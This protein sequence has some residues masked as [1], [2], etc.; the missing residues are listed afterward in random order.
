MRTAT[1]TVAMWFGIAAGI[2]GL[3]HGYFEILQGNTRPQGLMISSIGPPCDPEAVWNRCEPA[4]TIL[5]DFLLTGIL[6]VIFGLAILVWSLGF[7]H[8]KHGG[9]VL[10]LLSGALLL[11]GGGLF[12]PLISFIGGTAGL[13]INK[14]LTGKQ[15][16]RVLHLAAKLWPWPLVILMTWLLGQFPVGYF[17]NAFLQSI[18][19]FGLFLIV[20]M[21]P[22]SVY[23][24]YAY[25][26]QH[27]QT[28]E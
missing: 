7:M 26:V 24:A 3:E 14:P 16:G 1:K 8:R 6:A 17:F 21:L 11:F 18:M 23:S 9:V 10:I 20:V 27:A 25:D 22:V 2:A 15:P 5:P 13:K 28:G 12:P 19:W 4:M